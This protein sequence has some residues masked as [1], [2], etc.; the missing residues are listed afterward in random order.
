M[1]DPEVHDLVDI[2]FELAIFASLASPSK[3]VCSF[4]ILSKFFFLAP[5]VIVSVFLSLTA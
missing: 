4:A 5:E 1:A 2:K 3:S